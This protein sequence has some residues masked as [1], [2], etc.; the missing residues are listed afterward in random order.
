ML[1]CGTTSPT[2]RQVI[3]ALVMDGTAALSP[4][5]SNNPVLARPGAWRTDYLNINFNWNF[6]SLGKKSELYK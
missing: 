4:V 2:I 3:A 6:F 5:L 1:S